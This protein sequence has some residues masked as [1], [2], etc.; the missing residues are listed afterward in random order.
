MD[1]VRLKRGDIVKLRS[2]GPLMTVDYVNVRTL[3]CSWF[4]GTQLLTGQFDRDTLKRAT[5][6][7]KK[8]KHRQFH[9]DEG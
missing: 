6:E 2:G 8:K 7:K 5:F 3:H 9:D 4:E 1:D